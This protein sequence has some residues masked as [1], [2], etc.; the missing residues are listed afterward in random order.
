MHSPT[1][2]YLSARQDVLSSYGYGLQRRTSMLLTALDR[3]APSRPNRGLD[4]VDF[5]CADGAMLGAV[6]RHFADRPGSRTGLDVFRSG[7]PC[8]AGGGEQIKFAAV[9]LFK[10]YPYPL[11]DESQDV[12]IVSAFIKHHPEPNRF[13]G[14]LA[15]ILRP[16][17]VAV[18]LDPRPL[19]VR[20]GMVFGRFNPH[21]NPNIWNRRTLERTLKSPALNCIRLEHFERY[22]LAPTFSAFQIGLERVFPKV[23]IELCGLHQCAILRKL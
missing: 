18:L 1:Q 7:L 8:A 17:G 12:A 3:F 2:V 9:D 11:L 21:Y 14:E 16:N 10:R 19:V 6:S 13:L 20:V 4:V 22:W 23:A 5:G 15:R